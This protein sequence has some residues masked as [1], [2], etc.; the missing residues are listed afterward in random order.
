MPV[1][2]VLALSVLERM[3][4]YLMRICSQASLSNPCVSSS[5]LLAARANHTWGYRPQYYTP[6]TIGAEK[7]ELS[8]WIVLDPDLLRAPKASA[9][10]W[11]YIYSLGYY[12]C[13]L[14]SPPITPEVLRRQADW[15]R[16]I[17]VVWLACYSLQYDSEECSACFSSSCTF[18]S[19]HPISPQV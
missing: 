14:T 1:P 9:V 3:F 7:Y 4:S 15:L 18:S 8:Y 10:V 6:K 16:H 19:A 12:F 11:F 2:L 13:F 5:S 17:E